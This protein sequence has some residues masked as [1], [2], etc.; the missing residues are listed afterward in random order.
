MSNWRQGKRKKSRE[1]QHRTD[2]K[3]AKKARTLYVGELFKGAGGAVGAVL[4]AVSAV[5]TMGPAGAGMGAMAGSAVGES[6]KYY[7]TSRFGSGS[8]ASA[9]NFAS[10]GEAKSAV[11]GLVDSVRSEAD[12][13]VQ[14][15]RGQLEQVLDLVQHATDGSSNSLVSDALDGLQEALAKMDDVLA[16]SDAAKESAESWASGL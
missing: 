16:A 2:K 13:Q 12:A 9:G 5:K 15:G 8:V 7:I 14:A 1:Y 4:G 10:I 3:E 11:H 6:A